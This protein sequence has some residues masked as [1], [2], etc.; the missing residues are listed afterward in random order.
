MSVKGINGYGRNRYARHSHEWRAS[1][2][3]VDL[4]YQ[5][6]FRVRHSANVFATEARHQRNRELLEYGQ[7]APDEAAGIR[8]AL[9]IW[10][11]RECECQSLLK[12]AGRGTL[13][14]GIAALGNPARAPAQPEFLSPAVMPAIVR[15]SG[16]AASASP[17]RC[18]RSNA[19]CI[20]LIGF[21]YGLR[22]RM[23]RC[24]IGCRSSR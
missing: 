9:L 8:S 5:K 10:H 6:H 4:S 20:A 24:T 13:A 12:L 23:V 3:L 16:R 21:T 22:R 1:D 18:A 11:L 7:D 2:G 15:T 19:T 17:P 14:F